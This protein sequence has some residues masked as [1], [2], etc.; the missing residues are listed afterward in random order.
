MAPTLEDLRRYAVARTLFPPTTLLAAIERLGFV[1]ADP[2]RAPA[3]A[4]DLILRHRVRGYRAGDLERRYARLPIEEDFF[5]NYGFLPRAAQVLMHPRKGRGPLSARERRHA[6]VLVAHLREH[7]PLHPREIDR[8]FASDKVRNAWGGESNLTTHLLDTMHYRSQ[9]RVVRRDAGIRVYAA[10]D[11]ATSASPKVA[12]DALADLLVQTYAPL[13]QRTLHQLVLR[14]AIATPQWRAGVRAALGRAKARLRHAIVE[15]TPWYWPA[16][17]DI[18]AFADANAGRVRLLAPFDP[19]VWDRLRFEL[20]WGWAYRFEAYTP[21]ARRKLG[22]YALPMLRGNDV[23]GWAN[24]RVTS[25]NRLVG[26]FGFVRGRK[27]QDARFKTE[28][29]DE[30]DRIRRFLALA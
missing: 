14:L 7:G 21:L 6:A 23:I 3:R 1:Q 2:I 5:V 16:N 27:P 18:D 22:Y 30:M 4:Q 20:F 15:G 28:R 8:V 25:A 10:H 29:D 12:L 24:L 17:E 26:R 11:Y 19:I 13:P 9:L